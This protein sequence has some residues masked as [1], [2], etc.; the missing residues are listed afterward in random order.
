MDSLQLANLILHI[1]TA[2]D[3][4]ELRNAYFVAFREVSGSKDP[5]AIDAVIEAKNARRQ[6]LRAAAWR[7]GREE[8]RER[9]AQLRKALYQPE[10]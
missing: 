5:A 9:L 4:E 1:N 8:R 6:E 3:I 10:D 7:A 2:Q